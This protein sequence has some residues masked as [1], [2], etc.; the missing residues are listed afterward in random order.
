MKI[1]NFIER[2]L[3]IFRKECNFTQE[4]LQFFNLRAKNV[5]IE[6]IAEQLSISVSK[7]NKLSKQIR[8]KISKVSVN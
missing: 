4:E 5:P 2:E 8:C 7:A 1:C 3:E 6:T